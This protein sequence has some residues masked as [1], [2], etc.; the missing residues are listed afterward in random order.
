MKTASTKYYSKPI[1]FRFNPLLKVFVTASGNSKQ[2]G[3]CSPRRK[4]AIGGDDLEA[5]C[6]LPPGIETRQVSQVQGV[7]IRN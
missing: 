1:F 6:T 5:D 2:I 3:G 7:L 4:C